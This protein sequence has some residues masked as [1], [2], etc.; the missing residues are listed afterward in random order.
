MMTLSNMREN[1]VRSLA[2]TCGSL[3]CH[4]E[5][6]LDVSAFPNEAT[7]PSFGPRMVCTRCGA[8]GADARP[9]RNERARR[10]DVNASEEFLG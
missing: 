3:H 10:R 9:N 8:V 2:I 5:A 6:T 7:V 4:H 1:G